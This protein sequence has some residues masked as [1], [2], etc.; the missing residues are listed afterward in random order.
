MKPLVIYHQNCADGFTAAWI[1]ARALGDVELLE[2]QYGD[3]APDVMGREVYI[4][5]FSYPR[6]VLLR[7]NEIAAHV[8]VMDHHKT[9]AEALDGLP[10]CTFDMDECGASLAWRRFN[11]NDT[12]P[13]FV[14]FVKDRDLWRW[15]LTNSR[16]ISAF[17]RSWEP[18]LEQWDAL[19]NQLSATHGLAFAM[20]AGRAILREQNKM[21]DMHLAHSFEV[22]LADVQFNATQCTSK[23]LLSEVAG[24]LAKET[25]AGACWF[26]VGD[27][28]FAW[29]LRGDGR[30]TV[31]VSVVAK[32]YGGGGHRNAAGC[33]VDHAT[34]AK[35]MG[36]E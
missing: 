1:T 33:S 21:R 23:S 29:S 6:D 7:M 27:G 2:A 31:D 28:R 16:E 25:G 20:E 11:P 35:L 19:H 24:Q 14:Q 22:F 36:W 8:E 13:P 12:L 17:I 34:M 30:A 15:E 10:F 9:S 26:Y 18:S 3:E 4:V 5:D 32:Y